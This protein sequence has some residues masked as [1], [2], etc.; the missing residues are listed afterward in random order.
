MIFLL[1]Q[2]M[3]HLRTAVGIL[4]CGAS[5]LNKFANENAIQATFKSLQGNV[6]YLFLKKKKNGLWS[7]YLTQEEIEIQTAF[8][9]RLYLKLSP[10][11]SAREIA[12][13]KG[14]HFFVIVCANAHQ[15][16]NWKCKLQPDIS[17]S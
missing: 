9:F 6:K 7:I 14:R 16:A 3:Q 8:L 13:A 1:T 2:L 10:S 11:T 15:T 12:T 4:S 5:G 17:E